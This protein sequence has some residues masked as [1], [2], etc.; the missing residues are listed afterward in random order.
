MPIYTFQQ[1]QLMVFYYYIQFKIYLN[2][3]F[4]FMAVLSLC[5]VYLYLYYYQLL[6]LF[7]LNL[8]FLIFLLFQFNHCF[9]SYNISLR[10]YLNSN[11]HTMEVIQFNHF[12]QRVWIIVKITDIMINDQHLYFIFMIQLQNLPMYSDPPM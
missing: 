9:F 6:Y 7:Q 5:N 1:I 3:Y 2:Y 12:L 11:H 4:K 8:H 10:I